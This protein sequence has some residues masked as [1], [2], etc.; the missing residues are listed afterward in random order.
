MKSMERPLVSIV[1]PTYNV[2]AY[3]AECVESLLSQTYSKLVREIT[4]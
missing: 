4:V 1:V 2:E 3:L